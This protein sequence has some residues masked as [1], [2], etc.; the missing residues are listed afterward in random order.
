MKCDVEFSRD[1]FQNKLMEVIHLAVSPCT[2]VRP[3]ACLH[4]YLTTTTRREILR[5]VLGVIYQINHH[6]M[7]KFLPAGVTGGDVDV[8]TIRADGDAALEHADFDSFVVPPCAHCGATHRRPASPAGVRTAVATPGI[9]KPDVV[10]F[11]GNLE[12]RVRDA[13]TAAVQRSSGMLLLG[14]SAQ[15]FSAYRLCRLAVE[16]LGLPLAIVNIGATRADHLAE[17]LIEGKNVLSDGATARYLHAPT[18]VFFTWLRC[19][20]ALMFVRRCVF[21]ART[22]GRALRN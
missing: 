22:R 16:Q 17:E 13:A 6:W 1:V 7:K 5:T 21:A 14:T 19:A 18:A 11:G 9:I 15:V 4:I 8:V 12:P 10:F 3:L 20:F 2:C